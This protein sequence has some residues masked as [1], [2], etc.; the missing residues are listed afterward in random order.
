[1][2]FIGSRGIDLVQVV[3]ARFG[4]DMVPAV[5]A[6]YPSTRVVVD[7]GAKS[8]QGRVWLSYVTSRYGNV[9][10]M[11]CAA[12]PDVGELEAAGVSTSR[13]CFWG[14]DHT[15]TDEAIAALHMEA[16]GRLIAALVT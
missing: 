1:M 3:N 14:T 15:G 4:V 13:I 16:Y 7:M 8:G 12:Q 10:D 9:I 6:G 11:F 5:R 2:E